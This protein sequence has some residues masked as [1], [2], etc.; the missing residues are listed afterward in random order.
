MVKYSQNL[1]RYSKII[2]KKI[3]SFAK[4]SNGFQRGENTF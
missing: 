3:K 1:I 4:L 2:E